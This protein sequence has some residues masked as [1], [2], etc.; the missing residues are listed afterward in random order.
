[1]TLFFSGLVSWEGSPTSWNAGTLPELPCL[2]PQNAPVA[3]RS[4]FSNDLAGCEVAGK[5]S[6]HAS[7]NAADGGTQHGNAG[8]RQQDSMKKTALPGRD[9]DEGNRGLTTAQVSITRR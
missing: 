1:M 4:V 6:S 7:S 2:C 5:Q 9:V 8:L 3:Q